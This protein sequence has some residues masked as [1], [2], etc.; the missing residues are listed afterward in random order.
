MSCGLG[1]DIMTHLLLYT[2]PGT[3]PPFPYAD[4]NGNLKAGRKCG[5]RRDRDKS[6]FSRHG[7]RASLGAPCLFEDNSNRKNLKP[8]RKSAPYYGSDLDSD[9]Y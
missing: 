5:P 6:W 7:N 3:A 9:S 8:G 4:N 1:W 2:A